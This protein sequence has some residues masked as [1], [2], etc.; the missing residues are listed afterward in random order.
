MRDIEGFK[1]VSKRQNDLEDIHKCWSTRYKDAYNREM[2]FVLDLW[3][4][5]EGRLS[6]RF[7]D[8]L[9]KV[10]NIKPDM[11]EIVKSSR[12]QCESAARLAEETCAN[13]VNNIEECEGRLIKA[14]P[15]LIPASVASIVHSGCI[16][17]DKIKVVLVGAGY[18]F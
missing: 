7:E 12:T 6:E 3:G 17:N 5:R 2:E 10:W 16:R 9:L 13:L 15:E 14:I 11:H 1:R 18:L 8:V 4:F